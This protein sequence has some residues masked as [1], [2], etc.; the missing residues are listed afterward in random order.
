MADSVTAKR[1]MTGFLKPTARAE[2]TTEA[3]E[4]PA[5]AA[6]PTA[7]GTGD[8]VQSMGVGLRASEV[9]ELASIAAGLGVTRN[10]LAAWALRWFLAEHRAGRVTVPVEQTARLQ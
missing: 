1:R 2:E 4:T 6:R 10:A 9:A 5:P 7:R 3:E 8:P